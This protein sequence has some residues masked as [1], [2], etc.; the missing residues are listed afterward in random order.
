LDTATSVASTTNVT[1]FTRFENQEFH[2]PIVGSINPVTAKF[3]RLQ[4]RLIEEEGYVEVPPRK[5]VAAH[6]KTFRQLKEV[7]P[8]GLLDF[9]TKPLG[10]ALDQG[11]DSLAAAIRPS[12][13]VGDAL[14][15]ITGIAGMDKPN[16]TVQPNYLIQKPIGYFN[17]AQQIEHL[18]RL[19][20]YP[21]AQSKCDTEHFS[22]E[23]D[24]MNL[25]YLMSMPCFIRA[26][27]WN[28]ADESGKIIT[29]DFIH[30]MIACS[31]YLY[32]KLD[33]VHRLSTLEY[34]SSKFNF[35]RGG[36]VIEID[37]VASQLVTGRIYFAFHYGSFVPTGLLD[38]TSTYGEMIDVNDG[39]TTH[40][41]VIPFMSDTPWKRVVASNFTDPIQTPLPFP[42]DLTA[43]CTGTWS[44]RVVN[45]LI[46]PT[47]VAPRVTIN[48]AVK[49]GDDYE[50]NFI[51]TNNMSLIPVKTATPI[52]VQPQGLDEQTEGLPNDM[53]KEST[54]AD[55]V[56]LAPTRARVL[57]NQHFE[58]K[59]TTIRDIVKRYHPVIS[60]TVSGEEWNTW[61]P[62][63]S[64]KVPVARWNINDLMAQYNRMNMTQFLTAGHLLFRGSL[65]FKLIV[66]ESSTRPIDA[67]SVTNQ[68]NRW[69]GYINYD[70]SDS[71]PFIATPD[72][73]S[74]RTSNI[75]SQPVFDDIIWGITP[76]VN[77]PRFMFAQG[78]PLSMFTSEAPY[79]EFEVPFMTEYNVLPNPAI[80]STPNNTVVDR[81]MGWLNVMM[82]V[83]ANTNYVLQLY[84]AFGDDAR[85][86][87]FIGTPFTFI[88]SQL[89]LTTGNR[90]AFGYDYYS[91]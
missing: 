33:T 77:L 5:G 87:T 35:W 4:K 29:S 83:R 70:C 75:L 30:P 67:G 79:A 43:F 42:E 8:Q 73:K 53:A 80:A 60:T 34:Y 52:V 78:G 27:D 65:R 64:T 20:L 86:G 88:N 11:W 56:A 6:Y 18:D 41:I 17:H 36:I 84:M 76:D 2:I 32:G 3:E 15:A 16:D 46:C 74:L 22:T 13:I 40:Q 62:A 31:N 54:E 68:L 21:G 90:S 19:N 89:D 14:D 82:D 28:S 51:G 38:A 48:V 9:I 7:E 91:P 69:N 57:P 66:S 61:E 72:V 47:G 26:V 50:V 58:E 44:L 81:Q 71:T 10:S 59:Y 23:A 39:K 63:R 24:E 49:A 25:H 45:P 12:E 1:V 55:A 37:V 85:V